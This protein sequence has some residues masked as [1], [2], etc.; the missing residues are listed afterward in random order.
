MNNS[1][2]INWIC[3]LF[4]SKIAKFLSVC[5]CPIWLTQENLIK[6][7]ASDFQ[8]TLFKSNFYVK[9]LNFLFSTVNFAIII[10]LNLYG[11]E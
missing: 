7:N 1:D 2:R 11:T 8:F 6:L 3:T 10:E 5:S 9:N 4:Q